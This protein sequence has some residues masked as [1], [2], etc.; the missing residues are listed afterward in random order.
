MKKI[1]VRGIAVVLVAFA[2]VACTT[3]T[4]TPED[5][6]TTFT[7]NMSYANSVPANVFP[8]TGNGTATVTLNETQK[9]VSVEGTY[10]DM[11]APVSAAHIH[12]G[13]KGAMGDVVT[14]L[15][16]TADPATTAITVS[17]SNSG[18]LSLEAA[19][20]TDEQVTAMKAGNHYINI[21]TAVNQAGEVRGQISSDAADTI[22]TY[23][24]ELS[25]LNAS[26]AVTT[27]S[28]GVG[29][30]VATL[31]KTTNMAMMI[32]TYQGLT[33]AAS[34]AHIHAGAKGVAGPVVIP[35]VVTE[36]PAAAGSGGFGF[37]AAAVTAEQI[38]L[39]EAGQFY[40]N[41]HTAANPGGEIRGQIE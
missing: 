2:L 3:T 15:T 13:A 37:P 12:A 8:S 23:V 41:I 10:K 33:G 25:A 35:L 28:T 19:T 11:A 21:H 1:V 26:P 4:P 17:G 32:G 24:I 29:K 18:K 6:I 9:T 27:P 16:V 34:A 36:N 20:L 31:N 39:M 14:A 40:I 30:A 22:V 5:V 7:V 38:A